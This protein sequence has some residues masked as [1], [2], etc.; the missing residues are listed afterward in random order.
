[1]PNFHLSYV[2]LGA[3]G[4]LLPDAIRFARNRHKG[5]PQWFSK[6]GYWVGLLVLVCLGGVAAWLG[7]AA[8]WQSALAMG[9]AAPEV[10]S[11]LIGSEQPTFKDVGGFPIRRWWSR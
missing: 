7:K 8:D 5:F 10:V 11:R 3:V 9:F 1:M 2:V 6:L 4:G